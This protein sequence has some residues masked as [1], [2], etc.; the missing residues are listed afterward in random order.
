MAHARV[1]CCAVALLAL[2]AAF[3][4][5]SADSDII[6]PPTKTTGTAAALI[7]I[8]GASITTNAYLPLITALRDAYASPLWVAIPAFPGDIPEPLV[9][10]SGIERVLKSLAGAGMPSD[11]PVFYAGHSMGGA[12]IQNYV[13]TSART[14]KGQILMGAFLTHTYDHSTFPVPTLTI[15]GELDG[16]CRATRVAE[17]WYRYIKEASNPSGAVSNWPVVIIPGMSHMQ[18]ASGKP[19]TLV[20]LRDLK[21]AI[22][23]DAAHAA[24]AAVFSSFMEVRM[25]GPGAT[26]G[27]ALLQEK[28]QST[29]VFSQPIVNALKLEGYWQFAPP[30][31]KTKGK[32]PCTYGSPWMSNVAQGLMCGLPNGATVTNKDQFFDVSEFFPKNPLPNITNR[33][34]KPTSS[35]TLDTT[36]VTQLTYNILTGLDTGFVPISANQMEAKM[37]S[38]QRCQTDSGIPGVNFN[39]SDAG[40]LCAD[41][42]Q[43]AI[44]YAYAN[45]G[46]ATIKRFTAEGQKLVT[47][48]DSV[49]D[50]FP[51]W[52][53]T[54]LKWSNVKAADG[55]MQKQIISAASKLSD[56]TPILGGTHFCKLLSPAR[57]MEWLYVDGLRYYG[58]LDNSTSTM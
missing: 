46:A 18:F 30:C 50:V 1:A 8:Q 42:N 12:M 33:C 54:G 43:A 47:G 31:Y 15:G 19:P 56:N 7:F 6:L 36:T 49:D 26:T 21:P 44:S 40:N 37:S 9:L 57:A 3:A 38:R 58:S 41:I 53:A 5:A 34:A 25:G 22:S 14:A 39:V 16:L 52:V 35:C 48:P 29:G 2:A 4:P 27:L 51:L 28:V 20:Y 55:R 32:Q 13:N 17:N 23:Y 24:V 11:T 10:G 45:A